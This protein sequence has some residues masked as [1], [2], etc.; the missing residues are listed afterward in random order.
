MLKKIFS[1]LIATLFLC[2]ISFTIHTNNIK[3]NKKNS[4]IIWTGSKPAGFH[5]GN[6]SL[7]SGHLTF[8]HDRLV[9]GDFIIDMSSITCTDIE[10]EKKNKYL[11]DHLKSEDF[12]AVDEF[13]EAILSIT[14]VEK[15]DGMQHQMHGNMTIK[16]ITKPISFLAEVNSSR[17]GFT[18]IAKVIIDR[19]K[20]GVEYKSGNVFKDLGDKIIYDDIEFDIFLVSQK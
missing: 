3:A 16:G 2:Q 5:T 17:K 18:A 20:F 19:T 12:F 8:D 10:S 14:R 7:K 11:L 1:I 13:P 15:L 4:T 9:G 6:I